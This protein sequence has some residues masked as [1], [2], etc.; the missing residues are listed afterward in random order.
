MEEIFR[1]IQMQSNRNTTFMVRASYLQIY[2]EVISDLLKVD[3]T[4]LQI[5]EDKKK[6]VF[7]EGL[8]EWA[9]RSPNEIYSLMQKGALSR[10][11]ATTKMN[12]LSSRSHAVFII[13]VEQMTAFE[14]NMNGMSMD[15]DGGSKQIKVGKLNLVDLAGSERVRVTGATGKRLEESKKINQSLS[16]L[17]NV[18]AALTDPKLRSHIPYRDSKLTR[19]LEDSLGGNC[20]TTMMA[21]ISP[22]PDAFGE[23]LSTL[24]FATRAKKIKNEARINEDVDQRALLRRYEIELKKLKQELMER[25]REGHHPQILS[26]LEAEKRQAEEDKAAAINALE[27]QSKEYLMEKEEKKRLEEKIKMMNSQMLVGGKK[28]E[29]TP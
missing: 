16:C 28:V 22:S 20:K 17:G 7:V 25:N 3:R 24:K 23:S 6:G 27:A 1:F 5:R 21:M 29:D 14:D 19:L 12:D 13:I 26:Q 2:N 8:S 9:V 4:S 11:T 18:I 15:E 10:A